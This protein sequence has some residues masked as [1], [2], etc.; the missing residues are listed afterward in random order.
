MLDILSGTAALA[1][2]IGSQQSHTVNFGPSHVTW[3]WHNNHGFLGYALEA[4]IAWEV[5]SNAG[6]FHWGGWYC[7]ND[8]FTA[9]TG[10]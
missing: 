2:L 5:W 6:S 10:F 8:C 7:D 3:G 1:F 4:D 9:A